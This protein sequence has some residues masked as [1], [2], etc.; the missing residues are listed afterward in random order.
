MKTAMALPWNPA[1]G[2]NIIINLNQSIRKI[3]DL[4]LSCMACLIVLYILHEK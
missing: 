3:N 2:V 1:G 4:R